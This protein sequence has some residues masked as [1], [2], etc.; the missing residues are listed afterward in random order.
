MSAVMTVGTTAL[1]IIIVTSDN[2]NN[3]V[4]AIMVQIL[5]TEKGRREMGGRGKTRKN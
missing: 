3:N 4:N 5:T 1:V 2:N